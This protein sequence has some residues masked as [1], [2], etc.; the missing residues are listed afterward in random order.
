[1]RSVLQALRFAERLQDSTDV[2]AKSVA[3][4]RDTTGFDVQIGSYLFDEAKSKDF[5]ESIKI[6]FGSIDDNT[7]TADKEQVAID[8]AWK[9]ENDAYFGKMLQQLVSQDGTFSKKNIKSFEDTIR[10]FQ[11]TITKI[12]DTKAD[13]YIMA[14]LEVL[15][16]GKINASVDSSFEIQLFNGKQRFSK[17]TFLLVTTTP[18]M[19]DIRVKPV[20]INYTGNGEVEMRLKIEYQRVDSAGR[21]IRNDVAFYP[22][23]GWKKVKINEVWDVDF[24]TDIRGGKASVECK[25]SDTLTLTEVFYIRGTNPP[26]QAVRTYLSKRGYNQWFLMKMI[27]QESGTLNVGV[28]MKQFNPGRNYGKAWARIVGCPNMGSPRGFGL[29]QLDNWGT[30]ANPQ[31]ASQ[32]QLWDWKAN[33]DGGQEVLQE[34]LNEVD[35][36]RRE[37]NR[38]IAAWNRKHG[39]DSVSNNLKI[40]RGVGSGTTVQTITEGSEI[41]AVSPTAKQR[42]IYDASWIKKYNGGTFYH[43]LQ[44]RP[45]GKPYRVIYK[46]VSSENNRNYVNE[47]CSRHNGQIYTFIIWF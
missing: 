30:R 40:E 39:N 17:D 1:M 14:A 24:G 23:N 2:L 27:R 41:F 4:F 6:W 32:Q 19:P 44:T 47:L 13:A 38:T 28:D 9:Q 26:E 36:Q 25:I 15:Q 45:N 3:Q 10:S 8:V 5:I 42:D 22:S 11:E 21:H 18:G 46:T 35:A 31:Y 20:R 12:E 7:S 43:Q 34:K 37:H 16:T 33:L 29:M